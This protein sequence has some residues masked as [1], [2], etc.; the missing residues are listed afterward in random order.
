[1]F[2]KTLPEDFTVQG[3]TEIDLV[4]SALDNVMTDALESVVEIANQKNCN[5]RIAAFYKALT[6]IYNIYQVHGLTI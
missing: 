6:D 5:L 3:P 4:R 2:N 1:M